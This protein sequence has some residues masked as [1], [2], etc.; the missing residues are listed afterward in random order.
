MKQTFKLN[1]DQEYTLKFDCCTTASWPER[2]L[3]VSTSGPHGFAEHGRIVCNK[4]RGGECERKEL[5][6]TTS[7]S[8]D[9]QVDQ[10]ILF[11]T[12]KNECVYIDDIVLETCQ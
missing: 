10:E 3:S 9:E 7:T 5:T 4:A 1:P 11:F 6:F 12:N 2:S 8:T